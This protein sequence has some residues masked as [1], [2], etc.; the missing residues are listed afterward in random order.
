MWLG[1]LRHSLFQPWGTTWLN[2]RR[3]RDGS[4]RGWCITGGGPTGT[5]TT[6]DCNGLELGIILS[7]GCI[8]EVT[9]K[10]VETVEN[11]VF[12]G[13]QRGSDGLVVEL[14][15]IGDLLGLG[16]VWNNTL[17]SIIIQEHTND[18]YLLPS[19]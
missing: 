17:A 2:W 14:H 18:P 15:R 4:V 5:C 16:I 1:L 7:S 12:W 19:K 9:G 3:Q 6:R 10:R 13:Y 8:C 11:A